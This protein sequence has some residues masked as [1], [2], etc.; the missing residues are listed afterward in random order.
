MLTEEGKGQTNWE[1][2]TRGADEASKMSTWSGNDLSSRA[3]LC[4][5]QLK[6]SGTQPPTF[7]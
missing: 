7:F 3:K 6:F 2:S 1:L 4:A 5:S